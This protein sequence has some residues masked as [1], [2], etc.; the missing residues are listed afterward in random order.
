M[1]AWGP[2]LCP[3]RVFLTMVLAAAPLRAAAG[4]APDPRIA[5]A[6]RTLAIPFTANHGR[7]DRQVAFL[8]A[9]STET[10]FVTREGRLV[11]A[12]PGWTVVESF[13]GGRANVRPGPL[14]PTRVS[15]FAGGAP[16]GAPAAEATYESVSLGTVWPGVRLSVKAGPHD[17]EKIFR[18]AAGS[19]ADAISVRL[20]GV[21]DLRVAADGSL[22]AGTGIG[23]IVFSAPIAYQE[24]GLGLRTP[25]A[26]AYRVR[27]HGYGV[28]L[29]S[30]DPLREVIIDP[31]VRST[32]VGGSADEGANSLAI[33]PATGDL[34]LVGRTTSTD[35]PDTLG[36]AQATNAGFTDAFVARLSGD[37]KTLHQVTYLGGTLNEYARRVIFHSGTNEVIVMGPTGSTDFPGTSGGAQTSS[38]GSAY[39]V[40]RLSTDLTTLKQS[41]YFGGNGLSG[42]LIS[43][44]LAVDAATNDILIAG[45]SS[46]TNLPGTAAGAQSTSGGDIDAF[47][48]RFDSTLKTLKAAT[49][50]G[51][52]GREAS[53]A[54][55]VEPTSHDVL[56]AGYTQSASLPGTTNGAQASSAGGQDAF[57]ARFKNDLTSIIQATYLGGTGTDTAAS[58]V[59][60]SS[61]S[62]LVA[63][64]TTSSDFPH[65][66]GGA[67]SSL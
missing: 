5:A 1:H 4:S 23:P 22:V 20:D 58:L 33:N 60:R 54:L 47:V 19:T 55:A 43:G 64:G 61:G 29:G 24:D 62:L 53:F 27:R 14:S 37:L 36:G 13:S 46:A 52:S 31:I 56:M 67:Q 6:S 35:F 9:S 49:Y 48:A 63:G 34:Y 50:F 57:V 12:L 65:T 16:A 11:H 26:A 7:F 30:H 40:A 18:V 51:G 8:A 17:M 39:W 59:L 2:S 28:R 38:S 25:V 10:V 41:T 42:G 15:R 21:S 45:D 32:F 44:A 66:A 3:G